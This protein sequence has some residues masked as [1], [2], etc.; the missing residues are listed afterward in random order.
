MPAG[1]GG[2]KTNNN[3]IKT[4]VVK[5][6]SE[7]YYQRTIMARRRLVSAKLSNV[8]SPPFLKLQGHEQSN[9]GIN[10]GDMAWDPKILKPFSGVGNCKG[11]F[12]AF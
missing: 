10:K 4:A 6:L 7:S 9:R 3:N 1:W 12:K 5:R 2:K 11:L 8:S